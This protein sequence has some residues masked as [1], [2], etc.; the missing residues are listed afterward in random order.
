[1]P[2]VDVSQAINLKYNHHLSYEQIAAI[3]G[4]SKQAVHQKIKDLLPIPE[5]QVYINHRAD[6]LAHLQWRLLQEIDRGRLKKASLYQLVGALGLIYDKE[7]LERGQ[8]TSNHAI[9]ILIER[10]HR[11]RCRKVEAGVSPRDDTTDGG[12]V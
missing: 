5:T 10:L 11:E 2:T 8:S 1:M 9:G 7:R 6:I 3:Q 4:V 12:V